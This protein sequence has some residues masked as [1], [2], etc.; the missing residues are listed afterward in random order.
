MILLLLAA[1]ASPAPAIPPATPEELVRLRDSMRC[2]AAA[3]PMQSTKLLDERSGTDGTTQADMYKLLNT[4]KRCFGFDTMRARGVVVPGFL[5]EAQLRKMPTERATQAVAYRADAPNIK[6]RDEGEAIAL[7]TVRLKPMESWAVFATAPGS[8][9]EKAAIAPLLPTLS[10][11]TPA[12]AQAKFNRPGLR[13][14]L[15]LAYRRLV[16]FSGTKLS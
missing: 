5:A 7:C 4:N 3:A 9:E 8:P 11:C 6:A 16:L 13:A 12:T 10:E 15:A 2:I 1:A 14:V